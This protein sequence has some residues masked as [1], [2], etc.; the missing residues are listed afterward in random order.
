MCTKATENIPGA[1]GSNNI[2]VSCRVDSVNPL[3]YGV[4]DTRVTGFQ[5][6]ETATHDRETNSAL[7]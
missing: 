7:F 1:A 3:A 5:Q 2:C 6:K 4:S